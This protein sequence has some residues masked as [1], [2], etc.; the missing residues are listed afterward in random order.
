MTLNGIRFGTFGRSFGL[1][2]FV[3]AQRWVRNIK[4]NYERD[5]GGGG[6]LD[7]KEGYRSQKE[8]SN[9]PPTLEITR[10]KVFPF[11][12]TQTVNLRMNNRSENIY[13]KQKMGCDVGWGK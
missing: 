13:D 1:Q 3:V 12:Y 8:G 6:S 11:S 7:E 10:I 4:E 2:Q 5:A 9:I